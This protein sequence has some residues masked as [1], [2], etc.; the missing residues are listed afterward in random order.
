LIIEVVFS[1]LNPV[2]DD[3]TPSEGVETPEEVEEDVDREEEDDHLVECSMDGM[4]GELLVEEVG[5]ERQAKGDLQLDEVEDD[6]EDD[7]P[8]K[9]EIGEGINIKPAVYILVL[10]WDLL[11]WSLPVQQPHNIPSHGGDK[12]FQVHLPSVFAEYGQLELGCPHFNY[13]IC[14]IRLLIYSIDY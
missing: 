2:V 12:L 14:S 5:A 10:L 8:N 9:G 11:I 3:P 13:W 4:D 7:V 1:D 6:H